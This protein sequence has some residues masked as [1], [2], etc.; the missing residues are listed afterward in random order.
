M[1]TISYIDE[2]VDLSFE[3][4][5]REMLEGGDL[6]AVKDVRVIKYSHPKYNHDPIFGTKVVIC[7]ID[8]PDSFT[9]YMTAIWFDEFTRF[10]SERV[11][12][13]VSKRVQGLSDKG[14]L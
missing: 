1:T 4:G 9:S 14:I 5:L 3:K 2:K 8:V 12:S 10:D 7:T 6:K 11:R 13:A